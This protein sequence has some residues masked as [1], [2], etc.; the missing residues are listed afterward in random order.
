VY[1]CGG[2]CFGLVDYLSNY[3]FSVFFVPFAVTVYAVSLVFC[4]KA[5]QVVLLWKWSARFGDKT[6]VLTVTFF[7]FLNKDLVFF[8]SKFTL[9]EA[10]YTV[11]NKLWYPHLKKQITAFN[12]QLYCS[13][14]QTQC[15]IMCGFC[16][17][18]N[19][20]VLWSLCV[21]SIHSC[22]LERNN[23]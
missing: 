18:K 21:S 19:M 9:F 23:K 14:H 8:V 13:I 10:V 20:T 3:Q 15:V 2:D 6:V 22:V 5:I 4:R 1:F 7:Q 17:A 12:W 11:K 16:R